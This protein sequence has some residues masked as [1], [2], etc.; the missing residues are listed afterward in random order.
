MLQDFLL[1]VLASQQSDSYLEYSTQSGRRKTLV[2][3][4]QNRFGWDH[5]EAAA[6]L[7]RDWKF[8]EELIACVLLHHQ[9]LSVLAN[10]SYGRTA[11]GAVAIAALMPDFFQQ[12]PDGIT[13]LVRLEI[14][15]PVFNLVEIAKRVEAIFLESAGK[16]GRQHITFLRRVQKSPVCGHAS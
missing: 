10:K 13:E 2:G 3:F 16:P 1:P 15:W 8:P 11:A 9:G 14:A 12:H 5:A 6:Y 4:E 7:M